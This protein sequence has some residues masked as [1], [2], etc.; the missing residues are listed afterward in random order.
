MKKLFAAIFALTLLA[1]CSEDK[2]KVIHNN[3]RV[4]ELERRAALNDQLNNIQNQRL[5]ALEANLAAETAAREAAD[6]QLTADLQQEISDRAAADSV[7]QSLLDAEVAARIAGDLAQASN[8]QIEIANRIA[9]D[10]SNSNALSAAVLVQ[11]LTNFAVQVQISQINAKL[12]VINNKLTSLQNQINDVNADINALEAQT[13][14]LSASLSGL[15][16][17]LQAQINTLSVQQAATQA[18]LNAEGVKVFKCNSSSSTER[19]LKINGKFYAAMNR[20]T[21]KNIQ[22][23]TG[24]SSQTVTT[25]NMCLTYDGILKLP[26]AGGQCTPNSGPHASTLVPG[27]STTVSAYTTAT[28]TVVDSVKI[29]LDILVDGGYSTTDGGPS[30]SFSISGGGTT[31]SGLIQV[32]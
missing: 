5:D 6:A 27:S 10:Q 30:C 2:L 1:G 25:P 16:A 28:V 8:L 7:L 26:N 21:T 11:S 13:A 9:G 18:Q 31:Q 4:T 17:S 23:I 24:S 20:V 15:Q 29:A 14:A 3:D 12:V 19:I 22:V 32:Q